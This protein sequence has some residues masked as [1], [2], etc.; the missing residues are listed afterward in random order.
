MTKITPFI[1]FAYAA[2]ILI[3]LFLDPKTKCKKS[4]GECSIAHMLLFSTFK[5]FAVIGIVFVGA[6]F[7]RINLLQ[8]I[9]M[10]GF[11]MNWEAL[12][13][14]AVGALGFVAIYLLWQW[15]GTHAF[16]K[17]LQPENTRSSIIDA[18]PK[19][20]PQLTIIF[21]LV[22]LEAGVLEEVFF[23]GIM[24]SD[25]SGFAGPT[26]AVAGSGLLFGLAHFYQGSAGIAGT[27]L[28]GIWLGMTFAATGNLFVPVLGH[29]LGNLSCMMLGARYI[30]RV[31]SCK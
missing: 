30:L 27:S 2:L 25:V 17:K 16:T 10:S 29:F 31:R 8:V 1:L 4:K 22:S 11:S 26:W 15:T 28:L 12:G 24:Q 5:M 19:K 13:F 9:G 7:Y 18:L 20:L 21:A 23:R 3:S 6:A 14:G